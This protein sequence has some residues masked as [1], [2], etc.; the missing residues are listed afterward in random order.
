[1]GPGGGDW[2]PGDLVAIRGREWVIEEIDP[3]AG[4]NELRT[5][6]LACINDDAQGE[7]L[8]A[9]LDA[10]IDVRKLADDLWKSIGWDGPDRPEV[11]AAHLKT[12]TWR[13]ATAAD[14]D[15]F[16]APF[17]AGIR[18]EPYQLL[19]LAKALRLPR[20]NLL[21]ADDVGLGKTVEAG[22]VL[23]EMLLRR[24]VDY[25]VV[26]APAAMTAQWQDELAQ[27]F[28]LGFTIIDREYLALVRRNHGFG[29]NP[30][31]V[32]SR[33][34][35]SHSLI[36]DESYS[37]GLKSHFDGFRPRSLLILDEAHHAAPASGRA[38]ATDSQF[39]HAIDGLAELFEH[40]LFLSATPHNGHSN[41]FSRLLELLD[42][43]R[44]TRGM[45]IDPKNRDAVMVRR[46]KSDLKELGI[47]EFPDRRVEPIVLR[48]LPP[49]TP[50]LVLSDMLQAYRGWSEHGLEGLSLAKVRFL[51]SGLQQRLLSPIPAFARTLRKHLA[52]LQ[53][54]R[55]KAVTQAA[56]GTAELMARLA[57]E[58][59]PDEEGEETTLLQEVGRQQDEIAERATDVVAPLLA[60]FDQAI[61]HVEAMLEIA[62]RHER[63]SDQRV[64]W[65]IKWIRQNMLDANEQWND[66]RLLIFTEW[67]DTRLWLER[68]LREELPETDRGDERIA[69]FTG[70][71]GQDRRE[72][73]KL[74]FNA[75]PAKVPL[76]IL[77][78]T[79][80][81]R[82]GINLQT[83]CHDLVHFDLPWNP[84][85]MEQRNG[86]IDRKLQPA[87]QVFCRYFVYAQRAEDRV[88]DALARK[89][90]TIRQEL[91]S[92]GQVI[93]A[94]INDRLTAAGIA[95]DAADELA[96]EIEAEKGDALVRQA[97]DEMADDLE[98]RR[99]RLKQDVAD[100][101]RHLDRAKR[102]IGIEPT[103]MQ[104]VVETALAEDNV[105]LK[106]VPEAPVPDVFGLD[107][108]LPVFQSDSTW[109]DLF[110]ELREGRPPRKR[111]ELA[112]WR[113]EHPVRSIAFSPPVLADGRDAPG[114][115]QLHLEH[116]LVRRLLSRFLSQGFRAGLNRASVIY[117]PGS[118]ARV[119][120]VGRLA[121]YGPGAA[122]LHEE[123]IP[124]TAPWS[125]GARA[126]GLKPFGRAGEQTTLAELDAALGDASVPP[127][128]I[129]ERLI[130]EV[131]HDVASLRPA[132][133]D[134]AEEAQLTAEGELA[135]IGKRESEA[136]ARLLTA[137]RDRIRAA[138]DKADSPQLELDLSDPAERRQR[139]ADRRHW[140][141]R[142][143]ALEREL[144]EE[145]AR[146]ARSYEV[147]ASRLEPV[148]LVY[149]WPRSV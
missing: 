140:Q 94:R 113:Q 78:C 35:V 116:R 115:V 64:S 148:A 121:L 18:L 93:A 102:R 11:L 42:P 138:A 85:R 73:V 92:A 144:V 110:D 136:L 12:V 21:I 129:V 27:K 98:E 141:R 100:L 109:N 37:D 31:S 72:A 1:M 45:P 76:R 89:T 133:T 23:R 4:P 125:E 137:Q 145:P 66:R 33:F 70:L 8:R 90:D 57:E 62:S 101:E 117:G 134:R 34:I 123:L 71:T 95:K 127:A 147:R 29:A 77:I 17:R 26:T 48:D 22:L 126:G 3:R 122:R 83:R 25:V 79:D 38:Y 56:E 10:E 40:R 63:K 2:Q 131:Q 124:V 39:T 36:A 103:E 52:T 119:V 84:S 104:H 74:A 128:A 130:S 112:K 135:E 88:L 111:R 87:K 43:Q 6:A 5:V 86:R 41:S 59:D 65:L 24:R 82:E 149:L 53:R 99:A 105:P 30:W 58:V 118:Q 114:V 91:G 143:E 50:E 32:G 107:P 44:F 15:L 55:E 20:V 16:Q 47:A 14:R 60:N 96:Q 68:R 46:L 146:V 61:S 19:P 132:L 142:L 97:R 51:M 67:E 80:A 7:Q 13:S 69:T 54:H 28:G 106:P 9:V 139:E 81:A 75:D 49:N 108:T 120:F